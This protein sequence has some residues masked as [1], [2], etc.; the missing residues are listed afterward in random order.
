M[1]IINIQYIINITINN[2]A[3]CGSVKLRYIHLCHSIH[4]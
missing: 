1:N 4:K 3:D 2:E